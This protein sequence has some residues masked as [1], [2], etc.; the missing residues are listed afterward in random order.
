MKRAAIQ[1]SDLRRSAGPRGRSAQTPGSVFGCKGLRERAG[2]FWGWGAKAGTSD[3]QRPAKLGLRSCSPRPGPAPYSPS[4]PPLSPNKG[5]SVHAG[6]RPAG[7]QERSR[8]QRKPKEG[9]REALGPRKANGGNRAPIPGPPRDP[10]SAPLGGTFG[11][12]AWG[13]P[14]R[15]FGAP[16][17]PGP[18][19]VPAARP[20]APAP[21]PP[22]P[23]PAS[24]RARAPR[25][26]ALPPPPPRAHAR[27]RRPG[28]EL[29]TAGP[30]TGRRAGSG[31][32]GGGCRHAASPSRPAGPGRRARGPGPWGGRPWAGAGGGNGSGVLRGRGGARPPAPNGPRRPGAPPRLWGGRSQATPGAP[33]PPPLPFFSW[34][35][36]GEHAR[37]WPPPARRDPNWRAAPPPPRSLWDGPRPRPGTRGPAC[38]ALKGVSRSRPSARQHHGL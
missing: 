8:Q 2:T 22:A 33:A 26:R 30:A 23:F 16:P 28:R 15:A 11:S 27:A 35:G 4:L 36:A 29:E 24:P 5:V 21:A 17:P 19:R 38:R 20:P 31:N 1:S 9:G 13:T 18:R 7:C 6:E 34:P 10:S 37:A 3:R 14:R 12:G 25:P 32:T